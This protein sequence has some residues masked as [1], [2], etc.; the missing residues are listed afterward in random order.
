M[1]ESKFFKKK[2]SKAI[3]VYK[4]IEKNKI[5]NKN[6]RVAI[7]F[8]KKNVDGIMSLGDIREILL[9]IHQN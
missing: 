8:N 2:K 3:E 9:I 4:S 5:K 7:K 6:L 1:I